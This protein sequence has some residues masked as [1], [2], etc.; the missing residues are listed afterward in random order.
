MKAVYPALMATGCIIAITG[1]AGV[2]Q[3]RAGLEQ[4]AFLPCPDTP[5]CVS[6]LAGSGPSAILPL[7]YEGISREGALN[8]LVCLLES[9]PRCRI[10]K[11]EH[12][13]TGSIYM[14]AEFRSALFRFVDDVE[15]LL[16]AGESLI[17]V[18]SASRL[19]YSDMGVNRKRVERLRALFGSAI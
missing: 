6:S 1:C 19:G 3:S 15:F 14:H 16:P 18:K 7:N 8:R 13:E 2:G 17:Q 11:V 5:N 9:E 4:G 12:L 10:A